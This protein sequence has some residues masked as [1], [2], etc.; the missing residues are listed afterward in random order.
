MG[1]HHLTHSS[2]LPAGV[3]RQLWQ[4]DHRVQ[5]T[6]TLDPRAI[7]PLPRDIVVQSPFHES[8]ALWMRFRWDEVPFCSLPSPLSHCWLGGGEVLPSDLV[9]LWVI[10]IKSPRSF[11]YVIRWNHVNRARNA[12]QAARTC[13]AVCMSYSQN[14]KIF[15]V[16]NMTGHMFEEFTRCAKVCGLFILLFGCWLAGQTNPDHVVIIKGLFFLFLLLPP[17][18]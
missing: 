14:N 15:W 3:Q 6:D 8:G 16:S 10:K 2:F 4:D 12:D 9:D 13:E 1:S 7:N 17:N 5:F 11:A 18:N